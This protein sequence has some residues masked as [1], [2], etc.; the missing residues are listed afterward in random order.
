MCH[1]PED[2]DLY[3]QRGRDKAMVVHSS[4]IPTNTSKA[5]GGVSVFT[6]R[7]NTILTAM[8]PAVAEVAEADGE[9]ENPAT[10]AVYG[11]ILTL[12]GRDYYRTDKIP[13][14]G[15]FLMK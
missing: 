4:L 8:R 14:A 1:L 11:E 13:T 12:E 6:L 3:L 10:G 5:S 15:H 7:K 2:A 9:N